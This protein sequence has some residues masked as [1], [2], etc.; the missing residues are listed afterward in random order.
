MSTSN[1][2]K[3]KLL[4]IIQE[5]EAL[6]IKQFIQKSVKPDYTEI[7]SKSLDIR[8][9]MLEIYYLSQKQLKKK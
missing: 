4:A 7:S 3:N 5:L 6:H 8:E 1:T 2:I 9:N